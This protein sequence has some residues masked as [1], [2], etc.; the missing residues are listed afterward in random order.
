M[1]L[2]YYMPGNY[3]MPFLIS[4]INFS[5]RRVTHSYSA[6]F[7]E[8]SG[9][10]SPKH[11]HRTPAQEGNW[12]FRD[13]KSHFKHSVPPDYPISVKKKVSK[14]I[15]K[16]IFK[17]IADCKYKITLTL[18]LKKMFIPGQRV[19]EECYLFPPLGW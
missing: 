4:W 8:Y 9:G 19:Q 6:T 13:T 17:G 5:E 3:Y 15:C 10:K 2:H 16:I 7:F 14:C 11:I 1:L 18:W 12:L